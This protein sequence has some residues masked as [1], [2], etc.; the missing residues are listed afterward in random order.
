MKQII[1]EDLMSG[2]FEITIHA[3]VRMN[4]R[5]V[6]KKILEDGTWKVSNGSDL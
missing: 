1:I 5:M 4:Q 2:Q 3:A 6:Q